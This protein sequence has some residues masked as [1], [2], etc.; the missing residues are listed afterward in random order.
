[1]SKDQTKIEQDSH[2]TAK[3]DSQ[4][5][6]TPTPTPNPTPAQ[7][8]STKSQQLIAKVAAGVAAVVLI[9]VAAFYGFNFLNKPIRV[10]EQVIPTHQ[11][12]QD[13]QQT[14]EKISDYLLEES[15]IESS[16]GMEREIKKAEDLL[17]DE[18][19]L[20][21]KL[22]DSLDRMTVSELSDYQQQTQAYLSS[23]QKLLVHGQRTTD[24]I[25]GLVEP[26][27]SMEEL[28]VKHSGMSH[29]MYSDPN[30]YIDEI[31]TYTD[32]QTELVEEIKQIE[33]EG[34]YKDLHQSLSRQFEIELQLLKDLK[35]AVEDRDEEGMVTA[36][37]TYDQ[38]NL[39]E[40][41]EFERVEDLLDEEIENLSD[42]I[43]NQAKKVED[44]YSDLRHHYNF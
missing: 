6:S 7:T 31:Q 44:E 24:F 12:F 19:E 32:E 20:R 25:K 27:K 40:E 36:R 5:E 2:P 17:A 23:S 42:Q 15:G 21:S 22:K 1:M 33:T 35:Q 29:Y 34:K 9:A 28:S 11:I 26:F 16:E 18:Q 43:M 30:K 3:S 38:D 8:T 37:K 39:E 14:V 13:H 10:K 4:S 41:K